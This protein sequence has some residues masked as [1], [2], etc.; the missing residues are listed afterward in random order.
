MGKGKKEKDILSGFTGW[1]LLTNGYLCW[2]RTVHMPVLFLDVFLQEIFF[3]CGELSLSP[4]DLSEWWK[5]LA[6]KH[7]VQR[8]RRTSY[9][10]SRREGSVGGG[11]RELPYAAAP[12]GP[13]TP[14][15][16]QTKAAP[17]TRQR[18][19]CRRAADEGLLQP[20]PCKPCRAPGSPQGRPQQ[21]VAGGH[22]S[23][24]TVNTQAVYVIF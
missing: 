22:C 4:S 19:V 3:R 12:G 7:R 13:A 20:R 11:G 17:G 15:S 2:S 10:A 21:G 5:D 16:P 18:L 6:E 9:C 1:H 14:V 24:V 23:P 8:R